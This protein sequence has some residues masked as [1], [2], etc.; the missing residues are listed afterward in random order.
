MNKRKAYSIMHQAMT[1]L[2]WEKYFHRIRLSD[3][4]VYELLYYSDLSNDRDFPLCLIV[5]GILFDR[6]PNLYQIL[7]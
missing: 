6:V 1:I 3:D 2:D 4:D 5:R 7:K